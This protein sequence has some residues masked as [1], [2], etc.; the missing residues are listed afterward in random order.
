MNVNAVVNP[1]RW[2]LGPL[3]NYGSYCSRPERHISIATTTSHS[4]ASCFYLYSPESGHVIPLLKVLAWLPFL[5][6]QSPSP[7]SAHRPPLYLCGPTSTT[8]LLT[9]PALASSAPLLF[10]SLWTDSY[11]QKTLHHQSAFATVTAFISAH[12]SPPQQHPP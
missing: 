9:L 1:D 8:R 3:V 11:P 5:S 4:W 10:P 6:H 7:P 12:T 2:Q